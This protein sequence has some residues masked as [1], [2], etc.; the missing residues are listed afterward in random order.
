M[1]WL[2]NPESNANGQVGLRAQP[3]HIVGYFGGKRLA[4]ACDASD[5]YVVQKPGRTL[6]DPQCSIAWRGR[7]DELNQAEILAPTDL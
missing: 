7:R 6:R 3:P 2:A 5:G 1:F 4:F